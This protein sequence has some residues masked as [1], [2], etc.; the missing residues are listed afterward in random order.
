MLVG[1][2]ASADTLRGGLGMFAVAPDFN[3]GGSLA[4]YNLASIVGI[5]GSVYGGNTQQDDGGT[6]H[7]VGAS[8]GLNVELL[9]NLYPSIGATVTGAQT[10]RTVLRHQQE[11]CPVH[12]GEAHCAIGLHTEIEHEDAQWG[13]E[14]KATYVLLDG[15]LGL[16]AGYRLT[17]DDPL[18]HQGLFGVS[19]VM[20]SRPRL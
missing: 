10:K 13:V 20:S 17:F 15:W 2:V 4:F 3:L 7:Q 9:D 18:S 1:S 6:R 16:T 8:L 11:R 14:V 12:H 19:V 5:D